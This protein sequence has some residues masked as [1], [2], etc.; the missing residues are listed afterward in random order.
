LES[1]NLV[2]ITAFNRY[3]LV[4]SVVCAIAVVCM[5]AFGIVPTWQAITKVRGEI[6]VNQAEREKLESKIT[7]LRLL[8]GDGSRFA[9]DSAFLNETLYSRKPFL[10]TLYALS[11]LSSKNQ[12]AIVKLEVAPGIVA[13]Q[14]AEI[15]GSERL[16]SEAIEVDLNRNEQ[17]VILEMN[18]EGKMHDVV[19]F[20]ADLEKTAPVTNV[21]L[22]SL[23]QNDYGDAAVKLEVQIYYYNREVSVALGAAL[24]VLGANAET[25]GATL[26]SWLRPDLTVLGNT[27]V[28]G[29]GKDNLFIPY[30]FDDDG[31]EEELVTELEM[32]VATD[33]SSLS[34][35]G[36]GWASAN[37]RPF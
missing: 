22:G 9:S 36:A 5:L 3:Y 35:A 27:G 24:P 12:I 4:I 31:A 8:T 32:G 1:L 33:A 19:Q 18:V 34:T 28:I 17:Y 20:V 7:Q 21:S 37:A 30:Q 23:T 2:I 26:S 16:V 11:F 13:T 14:A 6:K 15:E 25:V 29:G 10:E